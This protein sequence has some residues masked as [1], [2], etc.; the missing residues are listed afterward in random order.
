MTDYTKCAACGHMLAVGAA[1][2]RRVAFPFGPSEVVAG[3]VL[4]FADGAN[5]AVAAEK[6]RRR[7]VEIPPQT[8]HRRRTAG[9][10]LSGLSPLAVSWLS[11]CIA[12]QLS[13][14]YDYARRH[15]LSD[16]PFVSQSSI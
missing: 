4:P 8:R 13:K 2:S 15:A 1:V 10:R 14:T 16:S 6:H 9:N 12:F 11:P 3:P 5:G 7:D